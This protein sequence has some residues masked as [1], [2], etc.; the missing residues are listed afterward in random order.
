M[1]DFSPDVSARLIAEAR[2]DSEAPC[3]YP[4]SSVRTSWSERAYQR[5]QANA[6][7]LADQLEA[8]VMEVATWRAELGTLQDVLGHLRGI[9]DFD[10]RSCELCVYANGTF[11]R[12][13]SMHA[14]IDGLRVE[15]ATLS[16]ER[17]GMRAVVEAAERWVDDSSETYQLYA[18]VRTYRSAKK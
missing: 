3:F 12:R 11:V 14:T 17:E 15:V 6:R 1:I 2:E 18:S 7:P 8:A 16:E 13:C 9:S 4:G 5:M 10:S